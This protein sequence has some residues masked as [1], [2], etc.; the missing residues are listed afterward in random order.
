MR[1]SVIVPGITPPSRG[2]PSAVI[3][4][5]LIFT[6]GIRGGRVDTS[7]STADL[8]KS[9][10]DQVLSGFGAADEME[11]NFAADAWIIHENLSRVLEACD[12]D[13]TQLLR[14]HVWLNDK[15]FF[16][17]FEKVRMAWQ[18][19]P[20]PSS[21]LGV[22][23]VGGRFSRGGGYDAIAVVPNLNPSLPKCSL[24]EA[25]DNSAFPAAAFYSQ[26]VRCGP[27]A[28]LAGYLPIDINR[29]GKPVIGGFDDLPLEG[30]SFATGR[31]HP[32]SRQGPIAAQVWFVYERIRE[33]LIAQGLSL[34]DIVHLNVFLRDIRDVG[35]FH[36]VHQ[37]FFP[38]RKPALTIGGFNEV[39]HRGTLVEIEPV[40]ISPASNMVVRP[41]EWPVPQ[42]FAGPAGMRVGPFLFIAGIMGL[43]T[44]GQLA[45]SE[46]DIA[47]PAGRSVVRDLARFE[48]APGFAAQ[49]WAAF[50]LANRV[51]EGA[52][53]TTDSLVKTSVFLRDL[54]DIWIYEEIRDAF[55][56]GPHLPA[57]D[58]VEVHAP[59]PLPGASVQLEI[60]AADG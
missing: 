55:L 51:C 53:M 45:K 38:D 37:T 11:G 19:V 30:R 4:N 22:S 3:S 23:K 39:G 2:Y 24:V 18:T 17:A 52:R 47:S 44:D 35:M 10:S 40:A 49:C 59:G 12:S 58:F 9:F 41:I 20:P 46:S 28:F 21:C 8:P 5:G 27:L 56:P 42:P 34:N 32:D 7:S 14:A 25:F 33:A 13:M 54:Q 48:H 6:S 29:P 50:E 36:R 15:R 43:S 31:S 57:V 1:R 16:P 26:A 60:I